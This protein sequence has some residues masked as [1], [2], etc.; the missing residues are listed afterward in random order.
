[1]IGQG[2]HFSRPITAANFAELLRGGE[3]VDTAD[4]VDLS[5]AVA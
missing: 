4:A 1:M 5:E 2:Y 3:P